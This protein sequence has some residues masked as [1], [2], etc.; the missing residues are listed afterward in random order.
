[1]PA[2]FIRWK[3]MAN[4]HRLVRLPTLYVPHK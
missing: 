3:K 2:T 4:G 1:M